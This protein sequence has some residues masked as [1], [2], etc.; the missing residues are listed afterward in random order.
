MYEKMTNP[1]DGI[2]NV[3]Y[4]SGNKIAFFV[5]KGTYDSRS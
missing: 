3:H 1:E 5:D 4:S 2:E